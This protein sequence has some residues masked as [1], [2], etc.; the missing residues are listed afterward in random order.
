[1]RCR[2][3]VAEDCCMLTIHTS[4]CLLVSTVF[5]TVS[6]LHLNFIF[7][8]F[9]T[10]FTHFSLTMSISTN[11]GLPSLDYLPGYR[12]RVPYIYAHALDLSAKIR[13][14]EIELVICKW[15]RI[16]RKLPDLAKSPSERYKL[17]VCIKDHVRPVSKRL[18][19]MF[20]ACRCPNFVLGR[21][22]KKKK[23]KKMEKIAVFPFSV[24]TS[25][26]VF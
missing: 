4:Q 21:L 9:Y 11:R 23:R 5:C 16:L 8:D 2:E 1:M 19:I 7:N 6:S 3:G 24:Y 15:R 14:R 13:M 25:S 12:S 10:C 18:C 26:D 17:S 22:K 20:M